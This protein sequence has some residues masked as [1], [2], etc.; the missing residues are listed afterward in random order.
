MLELACP[1]SDLQARY[2]AAA[3]RRRAASLN[4]GNS[5][6]TAA[7]RTAR[8][9]LLTIDDNN[10][11]YVKLRRRVQGIINKLSEA[12]LDP[13]CSELVALYDSNSTGLLNKALTAVLMTIAS[14]DSQVRSG[15]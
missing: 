14:T 4:G 1:Y 6:V 13:L 8:E 9:R 11:E 2:A 7:D 5:E 10:A 12:N 3:A 15:V